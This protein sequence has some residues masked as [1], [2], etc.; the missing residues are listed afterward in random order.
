MIQKSFNIM[1]Y[2]DYLIL[3][4]VSKRNEQHTYYYILFCQSVILLNIYLKFI[5]KNTFINILS[6]I[7]LIILIMTVSVSNEK[8]QFRLNKKK[9]ILY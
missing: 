8:I 5:L 9:Y 6:T 4:F 3:L 2:V 1:Q 7:I